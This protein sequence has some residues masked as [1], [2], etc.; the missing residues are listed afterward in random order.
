MYLVSLQ[1]NALN[2][3]LRQP[4]LR[5]VIKLRRARAL[6]RRHFLRVLQRVTVREIGGDATGAETVIA[7]EALIPA[8]AARRRIMRQASDLPYISGDRY[9]GLSPSWWHA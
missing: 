1:P 2:L 9:H 6:V 4:L 5:P 7:D 8:A 3:V